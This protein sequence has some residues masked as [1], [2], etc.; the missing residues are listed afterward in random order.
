VAKPF[1]HLGDVGLVIERIGGGGRT[2]SMSADLEPE[3]RRIG[4]HQ[5]VNAVGRDRAFS[6][7]GPVVA[8]RTEQRA[9]VVGAVAGRLE[10]TLMSPL[11]PGCSGK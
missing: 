6:L 4:S 8:D 5:L 1:L 11:V 3:L 2:Q 9:V 7:V 10:V